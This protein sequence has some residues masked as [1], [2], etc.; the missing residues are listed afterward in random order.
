M[1]SDMS[2]LLGAITFVAVPCLAI[3][4]YRGW[5]KSVR[6]KL[7]HWRNALGIMSIVLTSLSWSSLAI[8]PLLGRIDV[9][10]G[11]FSVDWISPIAFLTVAGTFLAFALKGASRI[12]A[13][14]ASLLMVA[15]WG[16]SV[17]S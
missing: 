12:E 9:S 1:L 10:T 16:M 2:K 11:F 7:P 13:I 4:A 8:L 5:A 6:Q 14:V 17:V 15:A 3:L